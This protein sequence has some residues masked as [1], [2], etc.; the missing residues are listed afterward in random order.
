MVEAAMKGKGEPFRH[1]SHPDD[2]LVVRFAL[3]NLAAIPLLLAVA[4]L[5]ASLVLPN[6]ASAEAWEAFQQGRSGR[7]GRWIDDLS[8]TEGFILVGGL[9]LLI[10]GACAGSALLIALRGLGPPT[11]EIDAKGRGV[12]R[13]PW[14]VRRFTIPPFTRMTVAPVLRFDPPI[15]ADDGRSL[16]TINLRPHLTDLGATRIRDRL[17]SMRPDW[18]V[19]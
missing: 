18:R 16:R 12:Y 19:D 17:K 7:R 15:L 6:L 2:V 10:V 8:Y 9:A 3:R 13:L 4:W 5:F 11:L 14:R 1:E